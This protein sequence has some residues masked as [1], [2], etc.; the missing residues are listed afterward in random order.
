M[1]VFFCWSYLQEYSKIS[2]V[3]ILW[4]WVDYIIKCRSCSCMHLSQ[5]I[6]TKFA[7]WISLPGSLSHWFLLILYL[8]VENFLLSDSSP[9]KQLKVHCNVVIFFNQTCKTLT[10]RHSPEM[11]NHF[12]NYFLFPHQ[13][14]LHYLKSIDISPLIR[15]PV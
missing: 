10:T 2:I 4:R 15:I 3:K 11:S 7:M 8:F 13:I 9:W 6:F 12:Y 1:W 14:L 5:Y